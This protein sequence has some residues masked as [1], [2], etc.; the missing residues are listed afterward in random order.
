MYAPRSESTLRGAI[1]ID[2]G[3]TCCATTLK[4]KAMK[5]KTNSFFICIKKLKFAAKLLIFLDISKFFYTFA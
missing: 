4:L 2:N 3:V 5:A 1:S